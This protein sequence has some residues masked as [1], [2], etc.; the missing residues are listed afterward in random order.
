MGFSWKS[1][2][3]FQARSDFRLL[4]LLNRSG[5]V[6]LCHRLHYLQMVSE[7]LAKSFQSKGGKPPRTTHKAFVDFLRFAQ[8]RKDLEAVCGYSGRTKQFR[9]HVNSLLSVAKAIEDLAPSSRN[10][11]ANP[12]YPWEE[13]Q[14]VSSRR[15]VSVIQAP[16]DFSF[17]YLDMRS[18]GMIR[19]M[20]FIE[21]CL[22]WGKN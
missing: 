13:K 10:Q 15:T 5:S 16:A 6:E 20:R 2:F 4:Q 21:S 22:R 9:A 17:G 19:I 12:E 14:I 1:A 7:K 18:L 3:L 8:Y 11:L